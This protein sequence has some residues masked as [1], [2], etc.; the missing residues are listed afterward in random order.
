MRNKV[1]L[2]YSLNSNEIRVKA[3]IIILHVKPRDNR[4]YHY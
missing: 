4:R 1:I 2:V 3:Y